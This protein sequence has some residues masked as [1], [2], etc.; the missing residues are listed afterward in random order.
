MGAGGKRFPGNDTPAYTRLQTWLE[1]LCWPEFF[2][3]AKLK[4]T[5][6]QKS[7]TFC[8]GYPPRMD[9]G[10]RRAVGAGGGCG[11]AGSRSL[12]SLPVRLLVFLTFLCTVRCPESS[13]LEGSALG[14]VIWESSGLCYLWPS[15]I[16]PAG[17]GTA[18][19]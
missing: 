19:I 17:S 4:N 10:Q 13:C 16:S 12:L 3:R 15:A 5:D 2:P 14:I 6:K 9:L 11:K 8:L 18:L 7:G 1:L